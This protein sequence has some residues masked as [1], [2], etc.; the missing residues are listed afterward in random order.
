MNFAVSNSLLISLNRAPYL[1][2]KRKIRNHYSVSN[3]WMVARANLIKLLCP[4]CNVSSILI[5]FYFFLKSCHFKSFL[6]LSEKKK[7]A[8]KWRFLLMKGV[9]YYHVWKKKTGI[10]LTFIV[11]LIFFKHLI[12]INFQIKFEILR[13][14]Y[15]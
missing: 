14:F 7:N 9:C 12:Q 3:I 1:I 11:H 13:Y 10:A 6:F 2:F 5:G 8:K 15:W 4:A